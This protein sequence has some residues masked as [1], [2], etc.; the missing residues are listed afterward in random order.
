MFADDIVVISLTMDKLQSLFGHVSDFC[1]QQE[2]SI[3]SSKTEL[4]VC[5]PS[6]AAY[7]LNALVTFG[8]F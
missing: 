2:L 3:N 7:P 5:G 4:M 1:G 6:V 8:E